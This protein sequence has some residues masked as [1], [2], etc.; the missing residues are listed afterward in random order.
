MS[1]SFIWQVLGKVDIKYLIIRPSWIHRTLP[2]CS[3][4]AQQGLIASKGQWPVSRSQAC[5]FW[6]K[7]MENPWSIFLLSWRMYAEMAE[8]VRAVW[9]VQSPAAWVGMKL[10]DL[11]VSAFFSVLETWML[12]WHSHQL[13]ASVADVPRS[14]H[15]TW[16]CP[17]IW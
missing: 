16:H 4:P 5:Q 2:F 6:D 17:V 8:Q 15:M 7:T 13:C 1:T 9:V 12:Q 3:S 14:C 10:L 11:R